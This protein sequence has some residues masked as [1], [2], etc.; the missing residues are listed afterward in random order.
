MHIFKHMGI[1]HTD[2]HVYGITCMA[3]TECTLSA[4]HTRQRVYKSVP[5]PILC[6][7][8]IIL[9]EFLKVW[10]KHHFYYTVYISTATCIVCLDIFISLSEASK[11][12][13]WIGLFGTMWG[14]RS[15]TSGG[16]STHV[17]AEVQWLLAS[18]VINTSV[19]IRDTG[20][21][22]ELYRGWCAIQGTDK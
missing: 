15:V 4:R 9:I 17:D 16:F 14:H 1:W 13:R 5:L 18:P 7:F 2:S 10:T 22:S 11:L 21:T 3:R 19:W 8:M 12:M 20:D 6:L